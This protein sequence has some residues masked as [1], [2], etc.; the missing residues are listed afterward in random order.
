MFEQLKREKIVEAPRS[1]VEA[2]EPYLVDVKVE[3]YSN[4]APIIKVV[5]NNPN[6]QSRFEGL[7]DEFGVVP[8]V[9]GGEVSIDSDY[10][11]RKL[12]LAELIAL[13][14]A[15]AEQLG[16][17]GTDVEDF[18][19]VFPLVKKAIPQIYRRIPRD[20]ENLDEMETRLE[21]E[22]KQVDFY[23]GEHNWLYKQGRRYRWQGRRL[24]DTKAEREIP[25]EEQVQLLE[26]AQGGDRAARDQFLRMNIGLVYFVVTNFNYR[27]PWVDTSELIQ[28]C[29]IKMDRCIDM[30]KP[31]LGAQFGSY[32]VTSME[33]HCLILMNEQVG[34]D[35]HIPHYQTV[36]VNKI[37]RSRDRA[38]HVDDSEGKAR[39]PLTKTQKFNIKRHE[40]LKDQDDLADLVDTE[41]PRLIDSNRDND[42]YEQAIINDLKEISREVLGTLTPRE[43]QVIR[44]R[45]GIEVSA[46]YTLEEAGEL[47][48]VTK[49]RIRQIE[50]KALRK[51][52][53]PSRA[54]KLMAFE[55][56]NRLDKH[57]TLIEK[58]EIEDSDEL[59]VLTEASEQ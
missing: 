25:A 19:R 56:I 39:Y 36:E 49:E 37:Q 47:L 30:Y 33:F 34:G 22:E 9:N 38:K 11:L 44:M 16:D 40:E 18:A 26:K 48:D 58:S 7:L 15:D 21:Q 43:A 59:E 41:D 28:E 31:T 17:T 2:L 42:P 46:D 10:D 8:W 50:A 20:Q 55:D 12:A 23:F 1:L 24:Y 57:G 6:E 27:F 52:R 35:I 51:L 29:F 45:F 54:V 13:D 53:H 4:G 5:F 3:H 32:A 14:D